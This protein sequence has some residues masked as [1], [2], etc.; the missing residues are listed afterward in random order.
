MSS[1][2]EQFELKKI[3]PLELNNVDLSFTNSSLCM[4]ITVCVVVMTMCLCLNKR[5]IV[6]RPRRLFRNR[7][8]HS[9]KALW[10]KRSAEK[11]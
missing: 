7:F 8:I 3:I 4:L 11:G 2:F 6:H 5:S 1:P 10:V 9:L